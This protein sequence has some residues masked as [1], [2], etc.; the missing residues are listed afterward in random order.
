MILEGKRVLI[1]GSS[2]GIGAAI[3]RLAKN[4]GAK[5]IL[6]GRNESAALQS[7]STELSSEYITCDVSDEQEVRAAVRRLEE[8]GESID[9]LINSAGIN[10]SKPFLEQSWESWNETFTVNVMGTVN[11]SKAVLTK[12][13]QREN[14]RIINIS[15]IRGYQNTSGSPAYA[16]S[17]A[18]II[19]LTASMAKEFA[20]SILVN[21][22]A[23]GFTN[24]EMTQ[25]TM[26]ERTKRQ[27]SEIPV[28]RLAEPEE[29]AEVVLFLASEKAKYITG[30]TIIVDGGYSLKR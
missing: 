13:L 5:V 15:S 26:T 20:P 23:P 27:I 3:A 1:T 17:K 7:L 14:G 9:V 24:T 30:Q 29:I 28:G 18:A 25:Q 6:H 19:N 22:V 2:R 21:A 10:L 11:F 12:M 4:Y 16:A 8:K